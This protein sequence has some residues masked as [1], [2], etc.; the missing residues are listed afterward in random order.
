M[1]LAGNKGL[2]GKPLTVTCDPTI[3]PSDLEPSLHS[4]PSTADATNQN[5][6][7]PTRIAII[8]ISAM[9]GLFL[10]VL[11][12][13]LILRSRR[14]PTPQ[15]GREIP[16]PYDDK[17]V[18][19]SVGV[20][21][22]TSATAIAATAAQVDQISAG[23]RKVEQAAQAPPPQQQAGKLS[24]V[25]DDRQKFDLQDLMR[26]SAEV[27]GSGNFGASY[28]AVLVDGEAL[29]VKRFKQMNN[30]AKE[31][32]HEHMRRL[33]RLKHLNLLPL[34]AYLYRKEEKL[35]VFDYV[36]NGSLAKHLHGSYR[37]GNMISLENSCPNLI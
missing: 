12:L 8:I 24:F 19:A 34:V 3:P 37:Q 15:L 25:R 35:L 16:P 5:K 26:A 22:N 7:S 10:I 29:V 18:S 1:H 9:L 27:L 36:N 4:P 23:V 11:I 30:V 17:S 33:G 31:D 20:G 13:L 2:C 32:F 6:L 28:K 14:S 21:T